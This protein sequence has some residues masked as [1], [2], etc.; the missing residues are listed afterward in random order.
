MQ[1]AYRIVDWWQYEVTA[2]GRKAKKDT[3][4]EELRKAP[5]EY[6]RFPVHGHFLSADFRRMVKRA[7]NY[8]DLMTEACVGV[9]KML[10]GL[11]GN[12]YREF[13]GYVLDDRQ[14]PI[15]PMQIA[16][17]LTIST[18]KINTIFE[19]LMDNEVRWV[20][21]VE[22]PVS[23]QNNMIG[24]TE[25]KMDN[26][27]GQSSPPDFSGRSGVKME[28]SGIPLNETE[29]EDISN[30]FETN[31][32]ERF[33]D[34]KP[35]GN[36]GTGGASE[37]E[38]RT[39]PVGENVSHPQAQPLA[40][41]TAKVSMTDT[42]SKNIPDTDT[43]S[44]SVSKFERGAGPGDVS[45]G[46]LSGRER[47]FEI[48]RQCKTAVF[49][50]DSIISCRTSS[51]RTTVND[52]FSQLQQRIIS[53]CKEPLFTM[54]LAIAREC[55]K[56]ADKPMAMFVSAMKKEP[57]CYVP[58]KLTVIPDSLKKSRYRNNRNI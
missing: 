26:L 5:L 25:V 17:L 43:D 36:F 44:A 34:S 2:K 18:T 20:E 30:R 52:I 27:S 56:V 47:L 3:P 31:R 35:P 7:W 39:Q 51:D 55:V 4:M 40:P 46:E 54:S 48:A 58:K 13:R 49:E 19:V 10:C 50:L 38:A 14:R 11:A 22:F 8:G 16:E 23:L 15:N 42:D 33:K 32:N 37:V 6:V 29:T 53:G 12:Q 41:D 21:L 1:E 24:I 28:S 57:F 45:A 9:Y